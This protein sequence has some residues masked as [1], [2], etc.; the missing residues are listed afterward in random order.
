MLERAV[1]ELGAKVVSGKEIYGVDCDIFSP[2]ALGAIINKDTIP[3]LKCKAVAGAANNQIFDEEAGLELKARGIAY[4][5][6]FIINAGGVIN[7]GQEAFTEYNEEN[8]LKQVHNIYNTVYN[9]LEE[10]KSTGEPEGVIAQ[11]FAEERIRNGL[12]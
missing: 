11:R 6:D 1:N 7:A 9:I 5:P 10:S 3:M 2:N 12:K 8:V 4:A